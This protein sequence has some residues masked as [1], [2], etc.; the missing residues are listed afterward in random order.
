MVNK[1]FITKV[2]KD[3]VWFFNGTKEIQASIKGNLRL[4]KIKI[5][6]GDYIEYTTNNNDYQIVN[7]LQRKNFILRPKVANIDKLM[8]VQSAI[9]PDFNSLFLNKMI[10]FYESKNVDVEIVITKLDL[11]DKNNPIF[12]YI[13]DL[14]EIGYRCY[15]VNNDVDFDN[16]LKTFKNNIICFVGNSGVGKSTLINKI[17][18]HLKINTQEISKSLNRG[19]HTTTNTSIVKIDD[20]FVV[21]TPGYSTV[22]LDIDKR[23]FASI[24]FRKE[25][26][27]CFNCKF[28]DCVHVDEKKCKI[29]DMVEDGSICKWRY[30]DYLSIMS[31]MR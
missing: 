17:K 7:I 5:C 31:K 29:K 9:E 18:P 27:N 2:I 23:D 13:N 8:I 6:A 30:N 28:N 19:K 16:M 24:F 22:D 25:L 21:D 4:N 12:Q 14:N 1:C 11:V 20:F 10:C 15:D 3:N 26:N